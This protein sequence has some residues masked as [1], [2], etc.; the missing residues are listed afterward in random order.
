MSSSS[1][2]LHHRETAE[3]RKAAQAFSRAVRALRADRNWTIEEAA[4]RFGVEPAYVRSIEMGRTNPSLAV[5]VSIAIAF[6]TRP[7]DLLR[8]DVEAKD[9]GRAP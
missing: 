5:I 9:P 8:V 2:T 4:E 6:D 1:R 3:F 7:C